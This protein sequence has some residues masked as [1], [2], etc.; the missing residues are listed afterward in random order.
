MKY[1]NKSAI[2]VFFK[3]L[4]W[5]FLFVLGSLVGLIGVVVTAIGGGQWSSMWTILTG[6]C[7]TVLL[8]VQVAQQT[9][10]ALG[11]GRTTRSVLKDLDGQ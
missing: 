4:G 11:W 6:A 7:N 5:R 1:S 3:A 10:E 9:V 8:T 2:I